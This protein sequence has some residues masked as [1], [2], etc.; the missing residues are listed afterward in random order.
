MICLNFVSILYIFQGEFLLPFSAW[1][2]E[3]ILTGNSYGLLQTQK[4]IDDDKHYH[5]IHDFDLS[6]EEWRLL[7]HKGID[8]TFAKDEEITVQQQ[9]AP[10]LYCVMEGEL[11]SSYV[12][13][14][15]R[16]FN[17]KL[18]KGDLFG[19]ITVFS[20]SFRSFSTV[21]VVSE[22]AKVKRLSLSLV[23]QYFLFEPVIALRFYVMTGKLFSRLLKAVDNDDTTLSSDLDDFE[24]NYTTHIDLEDPLWQ[25]ESQG[26]SSL[27]FQKLFPKHRHEYVYCECNAV[28]LGPFLSKK[29]MIY[30]TGESFNYVVSETKRVC[31]LPDDCTLTYHPN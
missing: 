7:M 13:A 10:Y 20:G 2:N 22:T 24:T 23:F 14:N 27:L 18:R 15:D 12:G 4:S 5:S 1:S 21:T 6:T 19:E 17:Y 30:I 16:S 9:Y 25:G 26:L 29:V 3:I 31:Y 28:L 11:N 8:L